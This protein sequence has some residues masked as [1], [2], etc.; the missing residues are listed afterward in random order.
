MLVESNERESGRLIRERERERD[1]AG[2]FTEDSDFAHDAPEPFGGALGW[3]S[4]TWSQHLRYVPR[5]TI[6]EIISHTITRVHSFRGEP[7]W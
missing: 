6:V 5:N 7:R 3:S 2:G 4:V 1:R